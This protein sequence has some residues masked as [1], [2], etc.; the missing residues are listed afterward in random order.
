MESRLL[1]T[2]VTSQLSTDGVNRREAY[3]FWCATA[4]GY[5][6]PDRPDAT[7]RQAFHAHA[8]GLIAAR[9]ELFIL[10]SDPLSGGRT[11]KRL[12]ADGG[13][14]LDLGLVFS[15]AFGQEQEEDVETI[16][17]PGRFFFY[18]AARPARVHWNT[19][20]GVYLTLRRPDALEAL[21]G[22]VPDASVLTAAVS[23][24]PLAPF[25]QA[26]LALL[27]RQLDV[28]S[29]SEQALLLDS[30]IDLA[31]AAL[32]GSFGPREDD[33][34]SKRYAL[35]LAARRFI[36]ARLADPNLDVVKVA[37]AVGCSRA[38]LYRAFSEQ[39]QTV[40]SYILAQRL[41]RFVRLLHVSDNKSTIAAIARQCGFRDVANFNKI[42]RRTFGMSPRDARGMR[43]PLRPR[44][45]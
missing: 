17:G 10:G 41:Q 14:D 27:A 3:D 16:A 32:K 5:F 1:Q 43:Q 11:T 34:A 42:F 40:V 39:E 6:E 24:S 37:D 4:F 9:G 33:P 38:T 21:G 30:T 7:S 22:T 2:C 45:G 12:R 15:G 19:F 29:A 26:Q 28:L 35:F 25:L 18:D 31:L 23:A 44:H 36:D 8:K 20:H 13:D